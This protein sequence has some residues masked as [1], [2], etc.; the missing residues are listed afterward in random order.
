MNKG[1]RGVLGDERGYSRGSELLVR[2]VGSPLSVS[3]RV[4]EPLKQ[5]GFALPLIAA[6][7]LPL[8]SYFLF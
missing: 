3:S 2:R 7:D 1:G 4:E 6:S 8:V 5:L